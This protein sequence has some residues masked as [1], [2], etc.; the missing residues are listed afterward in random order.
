MKRVIKKKRLPSKEGGNK[1]EK[2][3]VCEGS[4]R[5]ERTVRNYLR[6]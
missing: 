5:E 4:V 2:G 6:A 1:G 3:R